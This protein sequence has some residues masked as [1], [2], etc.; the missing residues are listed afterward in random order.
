MY[1]REGPNLMEIS[2]RSDS[3]EPENKKFLGLNHEEA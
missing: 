2:A 1:R 3:R